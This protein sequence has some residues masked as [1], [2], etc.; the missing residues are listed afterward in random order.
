M[1]KPRKTLRVEDIRTILNK[2][3]ERTDEYTTPKFKAGISLAL[4]LLLNEANQY[5]GFYFY[6]DDLVDSHSDRYYDRYY[7]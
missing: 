4:E 2:Q 7:Y 5:K 3:L 1:A 6:D